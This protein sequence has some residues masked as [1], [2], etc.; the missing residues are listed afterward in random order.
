[1]TTSPIVVLKGKHVVLKEL[2]T[3]E[4]TQ[5]LQSHPGATGTFG[6]TLAFHEK[7]FLSIFITRKIYIWVVSSRVYHYLEEQLNL[8]PCQNIAV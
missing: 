5:L 1:M 3:Q 4:Q 7:F 2:K 8:S 6:N